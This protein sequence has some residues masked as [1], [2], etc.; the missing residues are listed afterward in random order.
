MMTQEI[1]KAF[2]I[3]KPSGKSLGNSIP[4]KAEKK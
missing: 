1:Q 3:P 2:K 4:I